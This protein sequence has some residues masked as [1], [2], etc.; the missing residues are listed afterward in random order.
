MTPFYNAAADAVVAL[1]FGFV[2]FVVFG[3]LLVLR[4]PALAWAH[5]PAALWG[6]VIEF[7]GWICPLTPLETDLRRRTGSAA[8]QGDFVAHYIS[9]VLYP[10]GLTRTWQLALGVA[11]LAINA[12]IYALVL[13]RR[14]RGVKI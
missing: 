9:P 6:V 14:R 5:L 11:A 4:W 3:G 1:H 8:Y 13:A 2:V 10:A 12:S 7:G